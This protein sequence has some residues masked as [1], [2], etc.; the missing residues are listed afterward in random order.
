MHRF[1][2]TAPF[3]YHE[4][5]LIQWRYGF[6]TVTRVAADGDSEVDVGGHS[7]HQGHGVAKKAFW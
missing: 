1:A 2:L 5:G 3:P 4:I 6:T 7:L